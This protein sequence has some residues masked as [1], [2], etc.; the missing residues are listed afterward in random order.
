MNQTCRQ[1]NTTFEITDQDRKFYQSFDVPA[2]ELCPDCRQLHH[3]QC[4]NHLSGMVI[5]GIQRRMDKT[6]ILLVLFSSSGTI[7]CKKFLG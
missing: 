6:L 5:N 1:C 4:I 2:P 3:S 7:L